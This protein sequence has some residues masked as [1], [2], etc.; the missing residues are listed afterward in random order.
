M[1]GYRPEVIRGYASS[2]YMF[3]KYLKDMG[4]RSIKPRTILTSAEMLFP[5]Y[6][7]T[8]EEV[9]GCKV[10]DYYG[11]REIGALA[12]EC[13][14]HNGFHIS[15]ENVLMEFIRDNEQVTDESGSIYVTNFR[16]YGMPL[17]RYDIGD[18]GKPSQESC[19]CGRGLPIIK[20]LDGRA[21]QYIAIYDKDKG[22]IVL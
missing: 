8:I 22:K 18:I 1:E 10:Y 11:G 9:F 19:N 13:E 12:I 20:T 5:Q 21:S 16:N 3:A 4:V 14:E 6:R 17:I 7:T 15:A 2:V